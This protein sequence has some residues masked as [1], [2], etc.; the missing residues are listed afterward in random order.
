[1][2]QVGPIRLRRYGA[3]GPFVLAIHGG[4]AAVGTVGSLARA[5]ATDF[6]VLEPWQRGSGAEPLMVDTHIEDLD[7]IVAQ[8]DGARPGARRPLLGSHAGAGLCRA[9]S[10]TRERRCHRR[11]RHVR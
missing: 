11:L 7:L 8:C 4:P 6:R 3:Q 2:E 5:L 10:D 9:T 1:M